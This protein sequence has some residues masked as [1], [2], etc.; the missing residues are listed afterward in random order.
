MQPT[1]EVEKDQK[2]SQSS[3][4]MNRNFL[5]KIL[6]QNIFFNFY[7]FKN[8][9]SSKSLKIEMRS[10]KLNG[11]SFEISKSGFEECYE[12]MLHGSLFWIT[13]FIRSSGIENRN[14]SEK[15]F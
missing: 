14:K 6:I 11:N 12:N 3:L 8:S 5:A 15:R 13:S 9:K 2:K 7:F 1:H 10:F 4:I